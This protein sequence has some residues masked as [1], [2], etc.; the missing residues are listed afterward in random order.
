MYGLKEVQQGGKGSVLIKIK[1]P[2]QP[3]P[4]QDMRKTS[5]ITFAKQLKR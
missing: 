5:N 4:E 1:Q 3:T 2:T